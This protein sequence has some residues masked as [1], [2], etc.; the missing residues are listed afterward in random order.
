M[1]WKNIWIFKPN[2]KGHFKGADDF[3]FFTEQDH[4]DTVILFKLNIDL[5]KAT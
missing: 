5:A 1:T 2:R 4:Q 3:G